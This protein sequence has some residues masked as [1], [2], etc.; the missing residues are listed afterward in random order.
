MA[1]KKLINFRATTEEDTLLTYYAKL[2]G[3][4]KTEVLREQ[5]RSLRKTLAIAQHKTHVPYQNESIE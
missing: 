5:I 4:T 1:E 2:T 3:R